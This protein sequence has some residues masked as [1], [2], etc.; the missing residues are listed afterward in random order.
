MWLTWLVFSTSKKIARRVF[1]HGRSGAGGDTRPAKSRSGGAETSSAGS[2][3]SSGA[4]GATGV[5]T[6]TRVS[7]GGGGAAAGFARGRRRRGT[8]FFRVG[9]TALLSAGS[10][11]AAAGTWGSTQ[12]STRAAATGPSASMRRPRNGGVARRGRD[13]GRAAG[14]RGG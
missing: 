1:G 4:G 3:D 9:L 11:D 12:R 10:G 6:T 14:I 7:S 5:A 8:V 13:R 2:G